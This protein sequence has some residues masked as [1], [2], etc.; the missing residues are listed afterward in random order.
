M[1]GTKF[2]LSVE[3]Y[4]IKLIFDEID[5]ALSYMRFSNTF[6]ILNGSGILN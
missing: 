3:N 2:K 5:T 4:G 6:C 1:D